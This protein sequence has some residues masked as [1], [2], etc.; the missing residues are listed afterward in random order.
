MGYPATDSTR[1]S[2]AAD[3]SIPEKLPG[4]SFCG[5]RFEA[6]AAVG[7]RLPNCVMEEGR[8]RDARE[9]LP[10]PSPR[11]ASG[12]RTV[13][14][15]RAEPVK[16]TASVRFRSDTTCLASAVF[17]PDSNSTVRLLRRAVDGDKAAQDELVE[18]LYG[19]L[20]EFAEQVANH[21]HDVSLQATE[22]LHESYLR[23]FKDPEKV[24]GGVPWNDRR[25]FLLAMRQ[26]MQRAQQ[27]Y[28][29]K[30]FSQKRGG[31]HKRVAFD[32]EFVWSLPTGKEASVTA[33]VEALEKLAESSH[34]LATIADMHFIQGKDKAEIARLL[35]VTTQR[36]ELACTKFRII[37][38]ESLSGE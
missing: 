23:F 20:H 25:H 14:T 11:P 27:D 21:R 28:R 26:A 37:V 18:R 2:R 15:L 1:D 10:S 16:Y 19:E 13:R 33:L 5:T 6:P 17:V 35:E 29:R 3:W 8:T 31:N 38:E 12:N 7:T 24:N 32:M 30:K 34:T 22:L 9:G 36:V 4:Q